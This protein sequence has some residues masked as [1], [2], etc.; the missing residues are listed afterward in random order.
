MTTT[1]RTVATGLGFV[2]GPCLLPDGTLVVVSL[3][4]QCLYEITA[5]AT[6][7]AVAQF[8]SAPNGAT[9][10]TGGEVYLAAFSGHWPARPDCTGP[11]GVFAWRRDMPLAEI[12]PAPSAPNDLCFGPDGWLYVTDP[13]RGSSGGRLWRI[14]I[15]SGRSEILATVD[16]YPNGIGFDADDH[17]WVADTAGRR[18]VEYGSVAGGLSDA[19]REVP[20]PFGRPDGFAFDVDGHVIVAAPGTDEHPAA[21]VEVFD[22][23][24]DLVDVL[25]QGGSTYITNI[26]LDAD[27]TA[28]ITES[29]HGQVLALDGAC[30]GGLPLHPFR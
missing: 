24:G 1:P 11:G 3:D 23:A 9:A 28:F 19:V 5:D 25:L 29:Q 13:V 10:G 7:V 14:D 18:L 8:D 17:L 21:S 27:G 16:W 30:A 22:A 6:A 2:E 20:L 15:G 4:H 26:V 12:S